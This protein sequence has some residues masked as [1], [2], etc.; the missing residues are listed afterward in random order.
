MIDRKIESFYAVGKHGCNAHI[1]AVAYEDGRVTA[2]A[3]LDKL[4]EGQ[5]LKALRE[6]WPG[7]EWKAV[8]CGLDAD[9]HWLADGKKAG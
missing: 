8:K 2:T 4:T 9:G 6:R 3:D 5:L 1:E 7:L